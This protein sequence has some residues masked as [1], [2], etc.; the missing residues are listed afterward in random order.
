M[1][2]S[3]KSLSEFTHFTVENGKQYILTTLSELEHNK[4]MMNFLGFITKK[5]YLLIS[6][7][8]DKIFFIDNTAIFE[9]KI[10][11]NLFIVWPSYFPENT[12]YHFDKYIQKLNFLLANELKLS[13]SEKL[14]KLLEKKIVIYS[15]INTNL[16]NYYKNGPINSGELTVF[17]FRMPESNVSVKYYEYTMKMNQYIYNTL[18]KQIQKL[19]QEE[20]QQHFKFQNEEEIMSF[21]QN[22]GKRPRTFE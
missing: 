13:H 5:Q 2:T 12:A 16:P 17:N 10:F 6:D 15:P 7:K 18:P 19:K 3:I 1:N 20:K 9:V 4:Y 21:N 22:A 8:N 14:L 11:S